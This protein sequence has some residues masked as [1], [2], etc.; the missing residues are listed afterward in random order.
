MTMSFILMFLKMSVKHF[1]CKIKTTKP[2][3]KSLFFVIF[4]TKMLLLLDYLCFKLVIK[5]F[6]SSFYKT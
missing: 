6:L 5:T 2:N 3:N 1:Y 4:F